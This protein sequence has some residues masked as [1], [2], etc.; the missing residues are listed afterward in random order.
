VGSNAF[1]VK[2]DSEKAGDES[3]LYATYLGDSANDQGNSIAVN[4]DGQVYVTRHI[5]DLT[6]PGA[7]TGVPPYGK[8]Y[9]AKIDPS[10]SG[11][12]S[13][14]WD[15]LIVPSGLPSGVAVDAA[16]DAYVVG[17]TN[18]SNL[19]VTPGAF[20]ANLSGGNCE[21]IPVCNPPP[22][23]PLACGVPPGPPPTSF[24][25]IPCSDAF[26]MKFN[27]A[28]T[29]LLYSTY[30][31]NNSSGEFPRSIAVDSAKNVYVTGIGG[32]PFTP[33][34]FQDAT[35]NGFVAKL[36]LGA[37]SA[38][39][40]AV[41]AANYRG[42][43]LAQ[44]S[45]AVAFHDIVGP[46]SANLQMKVID[47]AGTERIAPV[48]FSGFGQVNLQIPPGTAIG[49]A[50]ASI[51]SNGVAI[52]VGALQVV[53]VAPGVFSLDASG[54][55]V[56]A[57]FVQRHKPDGSFTQESIFRFDPTL[58]KFIAVPIDLGPETDR[59]FLAIF[60]TGWR[61]R[62]SETSAQ[63]KIGGVDVPV[64]YVGLQPSN[65]GLDQINVE[66]IRTLAGKGEADLE[67]TVDGIAANTTRVAIR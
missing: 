22:P 44:E 26:I 10:K 20:Q 62:S 29:A 45:L 59:V 28:G 37:R 57:A 65:V 53:K 34:A 25:E 15:R 60:G 11:A 18:A 52:A 8:V 40:V 49:D 47:S 56:V 61:F 39:A 3:L 41:S 7:A 36:D 55:G 50:V 51:I 38:N 54:S 13:L 35:G 24:I 66:L 63:V 46:G 23:S 21:R 27:A 42:P 48:F 6:L 31:G 9:L 58:N 4:A 14:V 17:A 16:G 64:L 2:L 32:L 43:Q 1:V 30:L 12:P 5:P 19:P 33:G 67:V